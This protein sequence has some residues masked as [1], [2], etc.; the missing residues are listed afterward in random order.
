MVPAPPRCCVRYLQFPC[1][2]RHRYLAQR[3]AREK[4]KKEVKGIN[5]QRVDDDFM[6]LAAS[7]PVAFGEQAERPPD[8]K[9]VPRKAA[10]CHCRAWFSR[11][12]RRLTVVAPGVCDRR[13]GFACVKPRVQLG[14]PPR[15]KKRVWLENVPQSTSATKWSCSGSKP[16]MRTS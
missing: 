12:Q 3:M 2:L 5:K 1:P 13:N 8:I 9:H 15:L 4:A 14:P 16:R 10:V 11:Q 7:D 6:Q